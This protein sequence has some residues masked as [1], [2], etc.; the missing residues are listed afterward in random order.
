M[1]KEVKNLLAIGYKEIILIAQNVNSYRSGDNDFPKLLKKVLALPGDFWV[2]FS[3]S[4][5]KDFSDELIAL[6]SEKKLCSHLHLALQSG[7][8]EVLSQMNRKYTIEHFYQ[9][10]NKARS[11]CPGLAVTTDVIVGFP[12]ETKKQFENSEKA[13]RE[14]KFDFAY[15]SQ[16][17]PRPGTVSAKMKDDVDKE[18]K[19]RRDKVLESILEETG[20]EKNREYL[21]KEIIV[22]IDGINKKGKYYG[23][24]STFKNICLSDETNNSS[25]SIIG[26]FVK[27]K[28]I[29]VTSSGLE[30]KLLN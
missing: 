16:Y 15:V 17:S 20:L 22:L 29:S 4:H 30:G 25:E 18:E 6:F 19:N 12:G 10:I 23:K 28:I 8:N 1:I 11:V 24:T 2:R 21:N 14:L 9:I 27:V 7:D 13:F 5:P 3:S 26:N